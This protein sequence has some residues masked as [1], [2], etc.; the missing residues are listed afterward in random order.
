MNLL[1]D[2]VLLYRDIKHVMDQH[3]AATRFEDRH[4]GRHSPNRETDSESVHAGGTGVAAAG[5]ALPP[6]D[7]RTTYPGV[8]LEA[9]G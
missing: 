5:T 1:V 3:Y 8:I 9:E 4:S 6:E 2:A 7:T